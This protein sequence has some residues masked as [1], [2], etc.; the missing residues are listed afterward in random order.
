[1]SIATTGKR[2]L[3]ELDGER[4]I[5][6]YALHG[7]DQPPLCPDRLLVQAAPATRELM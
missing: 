2:H 4:P 3:G 6:T 1:M 7:E 5:R